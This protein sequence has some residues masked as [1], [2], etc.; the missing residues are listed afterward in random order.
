[1]LGPGRVADVT[2]ESV[3]AVGM[4]RAQPPEPTRRAAHFVLGI[5]FRLF[6]STATS[7]SP[8]V[9]TAEGG[10]GFVRPNITSRKQK[11]LHIQNGFFIE[12]TF[13]Q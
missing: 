8:F 13:K 5:L 3:I 11:V 9:W 1:M 6:V 12:L 2:A 10:R 7:P 4:L